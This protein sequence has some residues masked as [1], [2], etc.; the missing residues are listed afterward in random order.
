MMLISHIIKT[1]E[2]FMIE[3]LPEI[4]LE[5]IPEI[6]QAVAFNLAKLIS[7]YSAML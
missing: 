1:V 5:M 3:G 7:I 4:N 2:Y 6:I